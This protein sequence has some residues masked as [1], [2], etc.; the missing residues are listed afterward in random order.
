MEN[1]NEV[2]PP[3][4]AAGSSPPEPVGLTPEQRAAAD[5]QLRLLDA[6]KEHD[7]AICAA[8][9]ARAAAVDEIVRWTRATAETGRPTTAARGRKGY[10]EWSSMTAAHEGLVAELA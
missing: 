7:R 4:D 10:V 6:V 8:Q 1:T 2:P 9:A 5:T 3:E